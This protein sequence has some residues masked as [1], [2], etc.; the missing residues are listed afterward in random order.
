M[1]H[2]N[3]KSRAEHVLKP[4]VNKLKSFLMSSLSAVT[5]RLLVASLIFVVTGYVYSYISASRYPVAGAVRLPPT[6]SFG[7]SC[8]QL[9]SSFTRPSS[10]TC[11]VH[12]MNHFLRWVFQVE[13][14]KGL[15]HLL[16][17]AFPDSRDNIQDPGSP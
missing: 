14:I 15:A 1:D 16:S 8:L 2:S 7:P 11:C 17:N 6:G 10:H 13:D 5:K 4:L 12:R 9:D 3:R